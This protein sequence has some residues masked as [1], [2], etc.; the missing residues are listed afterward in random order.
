MREEQ[1]SAE[2]SSSRPG[3]MK[4]KNLRRVVCGDFFTAVITK[5]NELFLNK[6]FLMGDVK[7]IWGGICSEKI[8]FVLNNK[9]ELIKFDGNTNTSTKINTNQQKYKCNHIISV[10]SVF[11]ASFSI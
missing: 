1:S 9:N 10:F 8:I 7:M 11:F 4:F 3:L 5:K 2:N 6:I